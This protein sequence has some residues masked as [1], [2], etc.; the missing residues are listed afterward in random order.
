M[1]DERKS[2]LEVMKTTGQP[3]VYAIA[4]LCFGFLV[5]SFSRFKPI[6]NFGV[7]TSFILFIGLI[8]EIIIL[9]S[10]LRFVKIITLWDLLGV[11]L[12]KDPKHTIVI[13]NGLTNREARVAALLSTIRP[14]SKGEIIVKEGE[15]NAEMFVIVKGKVK[16]FSG[17]ETDEMSIAILGQ[18]DNFGEMDLV[19]RGPGW[20]SAAAMEDAELLIINEKSLKRIEKRY[21]R[22]AMT[23]YL[24][25][26]RILSERLQI[27]TL[28][29]MLKGKE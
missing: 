19:G 27:T 8:S 10:I 18:G 22:I 28:T 2:I 15:L 25:L 16:I 26:T 1:F 7:L 24:N 6:F 3:V 13:F 21:P 14:Y 23:I 12:G 20:T 17:E 4:T 29:A 9:P 11:K 5:V